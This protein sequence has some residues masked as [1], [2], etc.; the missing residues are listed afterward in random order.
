MSTTLPNT[1]ADDF[2]QM[3]IVYGDGSDNLLSAP[4]YV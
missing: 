3:A 1:D 2:A 4:A